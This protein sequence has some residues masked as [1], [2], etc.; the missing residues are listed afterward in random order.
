[1]TVVL[2]TGREH[3]VRRRETILNPPQGVE[4]RTLQSLESM[5]KDYQLTNVRGNPFVEKIKSLFFYNNRISRKNLKGVDLIY[6]PGFLV[7]N[8]FPFVVEIDNVAVLAYYNLTLLRLLKP[9][10]R[11]R[12]KS[13]WCEG[14]VCISEAAR[15]S[16]V[17]FFKNDEISKKCSV[18]YPFVQQ[19]TVTKS[20]S[21]K[22]RFLF[23]SSNF[24]LKG[25]K[26]VVDAFLEVEKLVP[27]VTLMI[28]TKTAEL[29][30]ETK[31]KITS[32][33]SIVLREA[34]LDKA[35][36]FRD[37]YSNADVFVLPTYQDSFGMVYLEALSAGL[38]VI[39]TD[40]FAVPEM[41]IDGKNGF[42]CKSPISYFTD[43]FLPNKNWW[44]KDK[45]AYAREHSFGFVKDFLVKKMLNLAKDAK[46]RQKMSEE[47]IKLL[48][49]RFNDELRKESLGAVLR[50]NRL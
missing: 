16:V 30:G 18:V 1:M 9:F 38:P 15:N 39:A 21:D 6:S 48:K 28:L 49:E 13:K 22:V 45:A 32:W 7:L 29:T 20:K 26:E 10:I 35:A 34:N 40:M 11:W 23:I 25:G 37:V 42:V 33:K 24:Y 14:I 50:M 31:V 46:L 17:N 43:E 12:L 8:R 4:F 27:G 3:R 36:L 5:K 19:E 41:V 44:T 47:S 2:F